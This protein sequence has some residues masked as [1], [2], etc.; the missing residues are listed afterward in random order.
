M[1]K[2]APASLGE[3]RNRLN[4]SRF[5]RAAEGGFYES[6]FQ[7]ANHPT[8]PLAFWIR[9]IVFSPKG[10]PSDA[11]GQLWAMYF[12][13]LA[14]QIV[15]LKRSVPIAECEFSRERLAVRID[16]ARLDHRSLGGGIS[17]ESKTISWDLSYEGDEPALLLL[18]RGLYERR[19]PS[20]KALTGTPFASY[21]GTL[22]VNG[23][24]LEIRDW[25]G[26]RIITGARSTLTD[27]PGGRSQTSTT[28]R[29]PSSS[30]LRQG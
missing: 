28:T 13:G 2:R 4:A 8:D 20:A 17:S 10:R 21:T 15:A 22:K 27:T 11:V 6:Y 29:K 5:E 14:E 3:E 9:Y 7:R 30:V 1:G 12:D 19:F 18:R 26:L 23:R 16:D 25:I 24:T